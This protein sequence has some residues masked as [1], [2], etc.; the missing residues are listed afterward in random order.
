MES[1]LPNI[2]RLDQ[3]ESKGDLNKLNYISFDA[4]TQREYRVKNTIRRKKNY[5]IHKSIDEQEIHPSQR[6]KSTISITDQDE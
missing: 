2:I 3:V 5:F 4:K 1:K 6:L